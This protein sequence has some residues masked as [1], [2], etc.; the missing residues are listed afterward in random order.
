MYG[1]KRDANGNPM[2]VEIPNTITSGGNSV[3]DKVNHI[4]KISNRMDG[5]HTE[6]LPK[7][8]PE[9]TLNLRRF[10][11]TQGST[12]E[13]VKEN[14]NFFL[15]AVPGSASKVRVRMLPERRGS[16]ST[17]GPT[18]EVQR[19]P[20]HQRRPELPPH[21]QA[22]EQMFSIKSNGST[23]REQRRH[24]HETIQNLEITRSK[25]T[26]A[27]N[28]R[29]IFSPDPLPDLRFPLNDLPPDLEG[30]SDPPWSQL[31][32]EYQTY[33]APN[34]DLLNY[35]MA[36]RHACMN[37]TA[38]TVEETHKEEMEA[39]HAEN[40]ELKTK[41]EELTKQNADLL[42]KLEKQQ[43]LIEMITKMKEQRKQLIDMLEKK[44]RDSVTKKATKELRRLSNAYAN[45]RL[46][47]DK[48]LQSR[49][50]RR[51]T[52][53]LSVPDKKRNSKTARMRSPRVSEIPIL[54]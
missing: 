26:D 28:G 50:S 14:L 16:S 17:S 41:N 33:L 19:N 47:Q 49:Q 12:H 9:S 24:L 40:K 1:I 42:K 30:E 36:R 13:Q 51:A 46:S 21:F 34:P 38:E 20:F 7:P 11:K 18:P 43:G 2:C 31:E 29:Y 32:R 53:H 25:L 35:A 27:L 5:V 45:M 23:L 10:S 48:M 39:V 15:Q 4:R 52:K 8:L 37:D 44:Q 22:Q 6:S 3:F 54:E